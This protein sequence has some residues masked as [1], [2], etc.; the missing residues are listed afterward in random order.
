M[1]KRL[2]RRTVIMGAAA[3]SGALVFA[4]SR[5]WRSGQ[6][7]N[8]VSSAPDPYAD[9]RATAYDLPS[10]GKI[11]SDPRLVAGER[12][13]IFVL[14]GQSNIC[15]TVQSALYTPT[16]ST[17]I[18]NLNILD[19]GTYRAV[20]P[21]VGC[22]AEPGNGHVF[23]RVADKL[24]AAGVFDRVILVPVGVGATPI[25][26]WTVGGQYYPRVVAGGRR[27]AAVGLPV[28][29]FIWAHGETDK[30]LG[31]SQ[32][33]YQAALSAMISGVRASGYNAPWLI[34]LS[35]YEAGATSSP[36]R[37]ALAAVTNG[38]DIFAG[39]D[40]DTLTGTS[41]NRRPDDTHFQAA[42]ADSAAILWKTAIDA[43]F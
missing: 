8:A 38:T 43:V 20:D 31:T 2:S 13:G 26:D 22:D 40:T 17:K 12:T 1:A 32:A 42:G 36:V 25:S 21:L 29:A 23:G 11:T 9:V 4:A 30:V 14:A 16:H 10:D 24:I 19:G 18:D 39:A 37:A 34:G 41:V 3:S 7:S 15:N 35:T 5:I 27:S 33:A 6:I 28:T